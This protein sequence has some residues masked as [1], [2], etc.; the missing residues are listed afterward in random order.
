MASITTKPD[1]LQLEAE[2]APYLFDNWFDPIES[3][4]RGRPNGGLDARFQAEAEKR[5]CHKLSE[6]HR[7]RGAA[8]TQCGSERL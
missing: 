7:R 2:P 3:E 5:G 1:S 4:V 6:G 8:Q